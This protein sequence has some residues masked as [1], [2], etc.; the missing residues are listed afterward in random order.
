[1]S[2]YTI[3]KALLDNYQ[4]LG[5][6]KEQFNKDIKTINT[7]AIDPPTIN[8]LTSGA[9]T[10]SKQ[11]YLEL[12]DR[13][14]LATT[15]YLDSVGVK[16]VGIGQTIS[17]IKDLPSWPWT[18]SISAEEAV[19]L[20]KKSLQKYID[21]VN[22]ALKVP[23]TQNQ[24]DA[25]VSITYNIG[26]GGMAG[27]TFMKRINASAPVAQVVAAILMWN[28]PPEIMGRRRKEADLYRYGT[29]SNKD[30]CVD[31]INVNAKTHKP[32]YKG[33]V[34]IVEYL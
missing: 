15:P 25:L 4:Q 23:V 2:L 17:D 20:Y 22:K 6:D 12:A 24:F 33:R 26:T 34:S 32:S 18:K 11:G 9:M 30:G 13:E 7:A 29:Y 19:N 3:M 21:A 5:K 27:S 10:L 31:K 14:G 8:Y 16:T 1:M 28:K